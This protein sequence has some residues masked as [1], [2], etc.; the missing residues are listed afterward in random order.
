MCP[1]ARRKG[2]SLWIPTTKKARAELSNPRLGISSDNISFKVM[3][4]LLVWG[5]IQNFHR[6]QKSEVH[7]LPEIIKHA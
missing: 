7:I 1:N 4:T 2:N 3:E 6:P 5:T